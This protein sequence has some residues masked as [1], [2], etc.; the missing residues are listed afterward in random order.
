MNKIAKTAQAL[1]AAS[2]ES[3]QLHCGVLERVLTC[4][5]PEK[6][7]LSATNSNEKSMQTLQINK[8]TQE[9]LNCLPPQKT[10][11]RAVK[12]WNH[13]TGTE[14]NAYNRKSYSHTG[15]QPLYCSMGVPNNH[16]I[17]YL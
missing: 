17:N 2:P 1:P 14:S 12:L 3:S 5:R 16:R 6:R 10:L 15:V 9:M 11:F 7:A 8:F 4:V 13:L